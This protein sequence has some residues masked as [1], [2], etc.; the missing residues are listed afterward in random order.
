MIFFATP[1][2]FSRPV[3]FLSDGTPNGTIE[4]LDP[5]AGSYF[6]V[7]I[8]G[9][10]AFFTGAST[11][12]MRTDGT[13]AGTIT[14]H[15]FTHDFDSPSLGSIAA[16]GNGRVIFSVKNDFTGREPY[17]ASATLNSASELVNIA[18]DLGYSEPRNLVDLNGDRRHSIQEYES[19]SQLESVARPVGCPRPALVRSPLNH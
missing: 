3:M 6:G 2:G 4:L 8:S 11:R 10:F 12:I 15:D 13:A 7:T 16:V 9:A 18:P 5:G 19:D 1:S 17:T 14:I